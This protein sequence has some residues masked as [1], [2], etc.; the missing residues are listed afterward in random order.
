MVLFVGRDDPSGR[1]DEREIGVV[2]IGTVS[3]GRVGGIGDC[4]IA[5]QVEGVCPDGSDYLGTL[6][7]GGAA[8][9]LS[10]LPNYAQEATN[11]GVGVQTP[12]VSSLPLTLPGLTLPTGVTASPTGLQ[13]GV[14]C[15]TGYTSVGGVC[16]P[17]VAP[18]TS[19]ISGV[20]NS[21]LYGGLGLLAVFM[22]MS[23][24]GGRRR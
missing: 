18:S 23:A 15:P 5:A 16:S 4:L 20:P 8:I 17:N 22:L 19:I 24:S 21:V 12:T 10:T 11:A 3:L 14:T 9:D 7:N 2:R 1:N 13:T 6:D